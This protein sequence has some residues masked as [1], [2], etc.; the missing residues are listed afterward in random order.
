M[1]SNLRAAS[2]GARWAAALTI[3]LCSCGAFAP[4]QDGG[5]SHGTAKHAAATAIEKPKVFLDK[6]P[7]V[8]EYQLNRLSNA[9]LLLVDRAKDS[10][11]YAPV[12]FAIL[13]RPGMAV[14]D[15]LQA[16]DGLTSINKTT[17]SEELL[18]ALGK[19]DDSKTDQ[20]RVARELASL[21][22]SQDALALTQSVKHFDR[23]ISSD[24]PLV[25]RVG[26]AGLISANQIQRARELVA[27]HQESFVD[28]M[29]AIPLVQSENLRSKLAADAFMGLDAKLPP[30]GR[31]RAIEALAA[32][33]SR[34]PESF[35][36]IAALVDEKPLTE[37]AVRTLARIPSE[38]RDKATSAKL[39]SNL[40]VRAEATPAAERT[41]DAFVDVLQLVD[42][43]LP[44][45]PETSAREYRQ[46]QKSISVRVVR[47]QTVEEE[48]RYDLK[49]FVAEAG[50]QVQIVLRNEDL[51]PH[52]LVVTKPG[53][54]KDVALLAAAMPPDAAPKGKQYVPESDKVLFATSMVQAGKQE[55]LTFEAPRQPGEYPFVCT[56]PNHWLRMYGVMVVVNDMDAWAKDSKPPADP[57]GN[58]RSFVRSWKL[59]DLKGELSNG[60]RGRSDDIGRRLFKE[61]TCQQCHKMRGEGGVVGP[62]LTDAFARWKGDTL[63]ILRELLE[64]SHKIDPQYASHSIL[65]NAGKVYSGVIVSENQDA[66]SIIN[67]PD[68]PAPTVIQRS[69][70]EEM[71][72]SPKSIMPTALLDQYTRDEIF[73]LLAF[74][75]TTKK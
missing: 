73:E 36:R 23:S 13:S 46:R 19:I 57:V 40:V 41:S 49:Y 51:M 14:Q 65:T 63:G 12:Y 50:R 35:Q 69:E 44:L 43:L 62:D 18:A 34:F 11:K 59:D 71:V 55:R 8:V 60:L 29:A 37:T 56:F 2:W 27:G 61:A 70:I 48:M 47:I 17:Q 5:K 6:S 3:W 54:L 53:A 10:P 72:K 39:V 24:R 7:R 25:R 28:F 22:V 52:N 21:L 32:I 9:Q 1:F 31:A 67:S 30:E 33:P 15:R 66:I 38:H 16:L 4:A 74:L 68:Q 75:V 26:F 42:S 45:L 20:R 58:Q 64:P